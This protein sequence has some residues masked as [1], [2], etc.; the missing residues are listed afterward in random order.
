MVD[1]MNSF[2]KLNSINKVCKLPDTSGARVV[3]FINEVMRPS[4]DSTDVRVNLWYS[5]FQAAW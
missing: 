1:I 3:Y 4:V 5:I 2:N